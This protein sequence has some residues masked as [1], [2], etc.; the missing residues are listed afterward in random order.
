MCKNLKNIEKTKKDY[1]GEEG[2]GSGA[3][4]LSSIYSGKITLLMSCFCQ[5]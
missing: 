1:G 4:T 3:D 5:E 2:A